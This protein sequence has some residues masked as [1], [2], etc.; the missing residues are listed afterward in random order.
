MAKIE[1]NILK[2]TGEYF[3]EAP[4]EEVWKALNDPD[5]L[6]SCI[7]GCEQ[8]TRVDDTH[9]EIELKA[10]VGPVN[11]RMQVQVVLTDLKPPYSY[12]I[13]G[14]AKGGAAGFAKG[15]AAVQ[16]IEE[17][18][19][20]RL[21]YL[22]NAN[23]GGKLAQVGSRLIDGAARKIADDFFGKFTSKISSHCSR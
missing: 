20:T 3:I 2:Q 21:S 6:G 1:E 11:A 18:S 4:R 17:D 12:T 14:G 7:L 22:V 19:G 16:L 23:V 5:M 9:F 13:Q 15:S 10:K 8:V